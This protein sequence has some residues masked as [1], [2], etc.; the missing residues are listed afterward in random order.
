MLV[1]RRWLGESTR[2]SH[3]YWI[4]QHHYRAKLALILVIQQVSIASKSVHAGIS[5]CVVS[6]RL[7]L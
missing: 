4:R 6:N 2:P 7:L 3:R 1:A 5:E